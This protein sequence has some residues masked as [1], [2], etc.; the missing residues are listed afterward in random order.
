[1]K[2]KPVAAAAAAVIIGTIGCAAR[3]SYSPYTGQTFAP[4]TRV[5]VLRTRVAERRHVE[6]GELCTS[7]GHTAVMRLTE[8]AK[9]LGA[10]AIILLGERSAGAVAVPVGQMAVAVPLTDTCAVA[11]RYT[12]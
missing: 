9:E 4:T 11:I 1:M 5:D 12:D 7:A 3:V 2:L 10:D 6:L 8:K